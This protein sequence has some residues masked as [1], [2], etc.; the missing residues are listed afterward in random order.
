MIIIGWLKFWTALILDDFAK[1][2]Q[3]RVDKVYHRISYVMFLCRVLIFSL[4]YVLLLGS[5]IMQHLQ[6]VCVYTAPLHCPSTWQL[7]V[8]S[9]HCR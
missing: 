7:A 8:D 5:L 1:I 2:V 9:W 4:F 6:R 3:T